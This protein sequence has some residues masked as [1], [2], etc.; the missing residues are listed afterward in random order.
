M[1]AEPLMVGRPW[2][3]LT[4]EALSEETRPL[5]ERT[6]AGV[7][8]AQWVTEAGEDLAARDCADAGS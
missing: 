6:P 1:A 2:R 3:P 7:R 4:P 5:K 8:E